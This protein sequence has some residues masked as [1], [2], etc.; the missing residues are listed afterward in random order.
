MYVLCNNDTSIA[1]II[2]KNKKSY[3]NTNYNYNITH[4]L[5]NTLQ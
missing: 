3:R 2:K 4:S 1:D 5:Y